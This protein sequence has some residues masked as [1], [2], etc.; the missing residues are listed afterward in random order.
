VD[1]VDAVEA[2]VEAFVAE[3]QGEEKERSDAV[4]AFVKAEE[5]AGAFGS[6]VVQEVLLSSS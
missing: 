4:E 3:E 1:T 5:H 2:L 6:S